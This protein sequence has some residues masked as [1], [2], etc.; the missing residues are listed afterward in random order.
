MT[1]RRR[2]LAGVAA[3]VALLVMVHCAVDPG[4]EKPPRLMAAAVQIDGWQMQEKPRLYVGNSLFELINGGAEI[5]HRFGF[6]QATA[7]LYSDPEGRGISLEIFEMR[8]ADGADKIYVD[9]TGGTGEP[10]DIGDQA[11]GEDYYLNFQSGRFLVTITGFDSDAE[12]TDGILK[13]AR[14]VAHELGGEQ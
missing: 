4:P 2:A 12:T 3:S 13:L 6:V 14:A 10:L 11:A 5:Y 9:K 7:A 8:D 1:V